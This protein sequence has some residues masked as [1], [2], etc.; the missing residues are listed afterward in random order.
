MDES[1]LAL[2]DV[3]KRFGHYQALNHINMSVSRGDVYALIGQNGAGKTTL[4]RLITGLAPL[5]QGEII[6]LGEN[7]KHY[8]HAL[9]RIGAIIETPVAFDK[10]TVLQNLKVTAI[11][12]GLS[13]QQEIDDAINFVG[14]KE[15]R[16]TK[17]KQLSLGQR[18]RL[19]LA[20]AVLAHPDF[21]ILDEPINGLDP[22][23]I[24]EF[25]QLLHR[26]NTE[27]QT[28]ILISSHIL[29]ELYQVS[30]RFGFLH[31][32]ALIKELTK[33][34]LDAE[35]QA[36]LLVD[37]DDVNHASQ[38][39]DQKGIKQF[40]VLNDQQI[41]IAEGQIE[42]A[43]L[44]QLLVTAGVQVNAITRKAGSLED[45]FMALIH[46]QGVVK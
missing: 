45:Y 20:T 25:R 2:H 46:E 14:L 33:A 36:G 41:V 39:L 29:T 44:N 9:S 27:K 42:S 10:L 15:K 18:Q 26:L 32:G 19:G 37:V 3:S 8:R 43:Q 1:V 12:H 34:E 22:A 6:L 16:T 17:A 38:L 28:T 11:Q 30:T 4:M 21:L 7:A 5:N 35:N 23:G 13:E 31:Q 24:I 40:T